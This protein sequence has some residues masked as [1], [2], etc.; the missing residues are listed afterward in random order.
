MGSGLTPALYLLLGFLLVP[1]FLTSA[2]MTLNFLSLIV[3]FGHRFLQSSF[4]SEI[5][6]SVGGGS[7]VLESL[8][9]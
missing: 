9:F 6:Y 8:W 4:V 7:L 5:D 1:S 2:L 3:Q